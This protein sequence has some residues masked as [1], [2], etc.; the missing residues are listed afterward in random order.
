MVHGTCSL[1]HTAACA[2][3]PCVHAGTMPPQKSRKSQR[4]GARK[5]GKRSAAQNE[6]PAAPR[7][8]RRSSSSS[9]SSSA[10]ATEVAKSAR[11]SEA[12]ESPRSTP[13]ASTPRPSGEHAADEATDDVAAS[14]HGSPVDRGEW[15]A[16]VCD[17]HGELAG[18]GAA[19]SSDEEG[20]HADW[21][22][23]AASDAP[24]GPTAGGAAGGSADTDGVAA[25]GEELL[26]DDDRRQLRRL[27]KRLR[28]ID[29]LS[30]KQFG[31]LNAQ[32]HEKLS[33]WLDTTRQMHILEA[34][35]QD[36]HR[37]ARVGSTPGG[38]T[39]GGGA[40][41][42]FGHLAGVTEHRSNA[43][44]SSTVSSRRDSD[45]SLADLSATIAGE[46][47]PPVLSPKPAPPAPPLRRS[48]VPDGVSAEAAA[49]AAATIQRQ[50]HRRA[51]QQRQRRERAAA[52][53]AAADAFCHALETR[54]LRTWQLLMVEH[55][56]QPENFGLPDGR[57][58]LDFTQARGDSRKRGPRRDG[59]Q[60]KSMLFSLPQK[61]LTSMARL[62]SV[63]L[64]SNQL[65]EVAHD[66]IDRA[67]RDYAED[68][69]WHGPIESFEALP[70]ETLMKMHTR[71]HNLLV[72]ACV[73]KPGRP[74]KDTSAASFDQPALFLRK[75]MQKGQYTAEAIWMSH[76]MR[77]HAS[78]RALSYAVVPEL[79]LAGA[80]RLIGG[81]DEL[82]E[83]QMPQMQHPVT[84]TRHDAQIHVIARRHFFEEVCVHNGPV[85]LSQDEASKRRKAYTILVMLG[86]TL[87][88]TT[89]E[90]LIAAHLLRPDSEGHV[91]TGINIGNGMWQ[92]L[93]NLVGCA[94]ENDNIAPSDISFERGKD[95]R[96][97]CAHPLAR[98]DC[99]ECVH[100]V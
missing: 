40:S 36:A 55:V 34:K 38:L 98:R 70:G 27:R 23:H 11:H 71:S 94:G 83:S 17:H 81:L 48:Q 67:K 87:G 64:R 33:S 62:Q 20:A 39:N 54:N 19:D 30:I 80:R 22:G 63:L 84:D 15:D 76:V 18:A 43:T 90:E 68:Q 1:V 77:H 47:S 13:R 58:R 14:Q 78:K 56:L 35:A 79:T 86:S 2:V 16:D 89:V 97:E 51:E 61:E 6:Q 25:V 50:H 5:A 73:P 59:K 82:T 49:A 37:A 92:Q 28:Q 75:T 74:R 8:S 88:S 31:Q 45:V 57:L 60:G 72:D 52:M 85:V 46:A 3:A 42:D 41:T 26:S 29:R 53:Q 44:A 99:A 9:N 95:R 24:G 32:E 65:L 93:C 100:A 7:P 10:S 4:K 96:A 21:A 91:K 12:H 69:A 66:A